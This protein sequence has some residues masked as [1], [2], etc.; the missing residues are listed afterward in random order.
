MIHQYGDNQKSCQAL[1]RE[2]A[3]EI[4]IAGDK[5]SGLNKTEMPDFT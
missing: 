2:M 4:I 1:E 5:Q 3:F